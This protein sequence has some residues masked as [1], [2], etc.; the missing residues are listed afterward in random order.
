[1]QLNDL[2]AIDNMIMEQYKQKFFQK[3]DNSIA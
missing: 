3:F 2:I 1:M